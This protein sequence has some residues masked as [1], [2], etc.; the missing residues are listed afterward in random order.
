MKKHYTGAEPL[1]I[2]KDRYTDDSI[3]AFIESAA[4]LK[5]KHAV[6]FAK[7]LVGSRADLQTYP[8]CNK[9][10]RLF[11]C[12]V[13]DL[14]AFEDVFTDAGRHFQERAKQINKERN[15]LHQRAKRQGVTMSNVAQKL[16]AAILSAKAMG[17]EFEGDQQRVT[18]RGMVMGRRNTPS[19]RTM[20]VTDEGV[21][22]LNAPE[23]AGIDLE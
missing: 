10:F 17:V 9:A 4:K 15:R 1:T 8:W 22:E 2:I 13:F 7:Q 11:V 5:N 23:R 14:K 21:R 18:I 6:R 20:I 12:E 16:M 3:K 19:F